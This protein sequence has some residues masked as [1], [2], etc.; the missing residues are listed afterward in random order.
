MFPGTGIPGDIIDVV[1]L[2]KLRHKDNAV[3]SVVFPGTG[4][5][6]SLIIITQIK[7]VLE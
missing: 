6:M 7:I 4:L 2:S 5:P 3:S 1:T